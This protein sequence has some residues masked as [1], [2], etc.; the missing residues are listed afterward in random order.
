[1]FKGAPKGPLPRLDRLGNRRQVKLLCDPHHA[2]ARPVG[3]DAELK[4]DRS[5]PVDPFP[6][7]SRDLFS[8]P[9][10]ECVVEVHDERPDPPVP[11]GVEVDVDDGPD[12]LV[13]AKQIDQS[14]LL[15]TLTE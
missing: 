5:G 14:R 15:P 2:A 8:L 3:R 12:T 13:R 9:S 4:S 10:E 11:K 6:C 7:F 1:M